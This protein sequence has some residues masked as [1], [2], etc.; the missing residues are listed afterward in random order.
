MLAAAKSD[1]AG[2]ISGLLGSVVIDEVQRSPELFLPIKAA[3][4]R[5]R[6][7]GRF[8]LT[9]SAN[10]L[11]LPK[12]SESLVGRMEVLTLWPLSQGEVEGAVEDFIDRVFAP[13]LAPLPNTCM[14][15][16]ELARRI[17][18]GGYPEAIL[19]SPARR[20]GSALTSRRSCSARSETSPTS[21]ASTR[22]RGC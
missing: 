3:V 1:P 22:S 10:V 6:Q 18:A 12:L 13:K 21:S 9:G 14:N 4:D 8:L 7:P 16:D 19:R 2:F 20:R 5:D 15:R 17:A 11:L